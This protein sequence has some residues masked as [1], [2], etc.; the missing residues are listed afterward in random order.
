VRRLP[1]IL[2]AVVA[3][4]VLGVLSSIVTLGFEDRAAAAPER[5]ELEAEKQRLETEIENL[6]DTLSALDTN[7]KAVE[8]MARKELRYVRPGETVVIIATPTPVPILVSLTE[9]TP[10][11]ILSLP[12]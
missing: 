2:A 8:S 1:L 12:D 4:V 5:Q 6:E 3:L 9:P 10:T 7:P 11:P